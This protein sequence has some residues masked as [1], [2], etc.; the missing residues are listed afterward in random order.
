MAYDQTKYLDRQ[1]RK[2]WRRSAKAELTAVAGYDGNTWL[3][4]ALAHLHAFAK[5]VP[6]LNTMPPAFKIST[7][8]AVNVMVLY[9]LLSE[10]GVP[11]GQ[12]Q[13][14]SDAI[15]KREIDRYPAWVRRLSGWF[16]F[17]KVV[18]SMTRH[19]A[20]KLAG[21]GEDAYKMD[22]VERDANS[23]G[24]NITQ[25]AVC[26]LAGKHDM[27][28][29]VPSICAIDT[30]L[31]DAFGWGLQRTQTIATGAKHC[32]FTFRKHASTDVKV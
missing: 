23:F 22:Y 17:T 27:K 28:D 12:I 14:I 10:N 4:Q 18:K 16:L 30:M 24:I 2:I 3:E 29:M 15:L 5:D 26:Q 19:Y 1:F 6:P 11:A 31:S 7:V 9:R 20:G 8:G 13:T 32:D 25:C 21:V